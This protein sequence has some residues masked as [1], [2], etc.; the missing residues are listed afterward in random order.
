ME[1][2]VFGAPQP[3]VTYRARPGAYGVAFDDAGRAAVVYCD[4]KGYF[5]LG[6]GVDPGEDEPSCICRETLE[7]TGRA[8]TVREKVCIGEEYTV[9]LK[10]RPY[11]PIGHIYLL[12]LGEQ[13]SQPVETDHVLTW[14]TVEEFQKTTFLRYQ[15]WAMGMAW[16]AY[17]KQRKEENQ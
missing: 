8:V 10:G 12:G 11:H 15:S 9:D 13:V 6:G 3:G 4:R 5:L 14:M 1:H 16:E 7:E 2:K 17:Q